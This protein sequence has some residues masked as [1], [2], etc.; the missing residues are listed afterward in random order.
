MPDTLMPQLSATDFSQFSYDAAQQ[1]RMHS[2]AAQALLDL[3][4]VEERISLLHQASPAIERLG[5]A[6]FRTGTEGLHGLSWLGKA[7]TLPQPIGL[8]ATWDKELLARCGDM[9]ATEVRAKHAEDNTV[10][11]NVWAPVVNSL[12]HPL[13]G[14]NEEGYSEDPILTGD[15]AIAYS[16]G[17]KGTK[18]SSFWKTVPT[19]KHFLAYNNEVDR[20]VSSSDMRARVLHEYEFPAFSRPLA[21]HVIGAVMPSYNLVNGRPNHV[22]TDLLNTLRSWAP[23]PISVVSDAGAPTN[24]VAYERYYDNHVDSHGALLNAGVD[25]FTDNDTNSEPNLTALKGALEAGKTTQAAVDQAVFRLLYLRSLT[26]EFVENQH[27][28]ALYAGDTD[29]YADIAVEEIDAPAHRALAREAAAKGA[30]LLKNN[31]VL[32]LA[33]DTKKIAVLGPFATRTLHDWYSGTPPYLSTLGEAF[34]ERYPE[35]TVVADDCADHVVIYSPTA[36]RYLGISAAGALETTG[37][38]QAGAETFSFT[39]WGHGITTLRSQS[40]DLLLTGDWII[41]AHA[42]RVGGWVTKETFTFA[43]HEDGTISIKHIATGRWL[44]AQAGSGLVAA[45]T[46]RADEAERFEFDV[47]SSGVD[48]ARN[49]AQTSDVTFVAVGNDPHI[50][51][52]ETEDRPDLNLP[53]AA[54]ALW[55]T[56]HAHAPKAVLTVIS[57]YPYALRE[58]ADQA[59][60]I[61]WSSHAGQEQGHGLVDVFAGDQEPYG[62]LAQEW[63]N[64]ESC[65]PNIL[66]YDI[67]A[68]GGTYWYNDCTPDFEFGAGLSY[69]SVTYGELTLSGTENDGSAGPGHRDTVS[70][71][72]DTTSAL[73]APV[74]AYV[75]VTNNGERPVNELV[76][77]YAALE[78]A[79]QPLGSA[80]PLRR[81]AGYARVELAPGETKNVTVDILQEAFHLYNPRTEELYVH[82]GSYRV[83]AGTSRVA[84]TE[85][86]WDVEAQHDLRALPLAGATLRADQFDEH[87]D[88]IHSDADLAGRNCITVSPEKST[89]YIEFHNVD[90]TGI[91]T[92]T[93]LLSR[94]YAGP[95]GSATF[96]LVEYGSDSTAPRKHA[97]TRVGMSESSAYESKYAW[98]VISESLTGTGIVSEEDALNRFDTLRITLTGNVR[99]QS[100][101]FA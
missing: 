66:D 57:S 68:S 88:I 72:A 98:N 86:L 62:R 80:A 22:A 8:A 85:T 40:N 38:T 3:L 35:A 5:I 41:N 101:S 20:A 59:D 97:L 32:P 60:A 39:D 46:T 75:T 79:S 33:H 99:I 81:L 70:A 45:D 87:S 69:T 2:Q 96:E 92:L 73:G 1:I 13:W 61:L 71:S 26:G 27:V 37:T 78:F 21:Q 76:E 15:C 11:L 17:L 95:V 53:R 34:A 50:L 29:P 9:V 12:R 90:A 31:G 100:V 52:R 82:P 64:D 7:T 93:A 65:V 55:R 89:G 48:R 19:L 49:A 84:A 14:R 54:Q 83:W 43:R 23:H 47:V 24:V 36:K 56:A 16:T 58:A 28:S 51:G 74:Q 18:G 10:S 63:V 42:Q 94:A 4:T 91:K 30:V 25:S 67:V 77:V 6:E 44:R